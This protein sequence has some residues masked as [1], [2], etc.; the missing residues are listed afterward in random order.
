VPAQSF[1]GIWMRPPTAQELNGLVEDYFKE[2]N[3]V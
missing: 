3:T 1:A 2:K